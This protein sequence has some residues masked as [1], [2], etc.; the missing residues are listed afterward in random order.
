MAD[1]RDDPHGQELSRTAKNNSK[2]DIRLP[3]VAD[4]D[5]DQS[6][7][8]ISPCFDNN[9]CFEARIENIDNVGGV[10]HR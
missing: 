1:Q 6:S 7:Y 10:R 8:I 5:S 3:T 4:Q 9:N 2:N